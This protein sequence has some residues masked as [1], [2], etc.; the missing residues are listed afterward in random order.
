MQ[1]PVNCPLLLLTSFHWMS[2]KNSRVVLQEG[3]VFLRQD[4][5]VELCRE[6]R[7]FCF[8]YLVWSM[9]AVQKWW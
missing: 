8:I 6:G 1:P 2:M 3:E 5:F 4:L 7:T 9:N